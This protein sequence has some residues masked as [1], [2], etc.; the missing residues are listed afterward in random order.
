[1]M[2]PAIAIQGVGLVSSVGLSAP[3]SCAAIRAK[4]ANPSVTGF[5]GSSGERIIGHQVVLERPWRGVAK[6]ARMAAM[7]IAEG[8]SEVP[9]K[10]WTTIPLLLCVSERNRPGR[11]MNLEE[12]LPKSIGDLLGLPF[13]RQSAIIAHGRV[14]VVIALTQARKLFSQRGVNRVLI[15]AVDSLL[16][17]PTLRHLEGR[18]RLLGKRNSDGFLPGEGA[19]ALLLG[20]PRGSQ[21]L[22]CAGAGFGFEAATIASDMP[23][24][25]IGLTS[26][27]RGALGECGLAT[28][29]LDY[30]IADLSGEQY[31]FKEAALALLRSLR[32]RKPEFDL[33]HP[34]ECTGEAGAT[35]GAVPIAVGYMAGRVGYSPGDH[36]LAHMS[37]DNGERAAAVFRYVGA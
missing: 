24:R 8:L 4:V 6:L 23:L 3:T 18:G 17:W 33:W 30:R 28:H 26:A 12:S 19:C 15:V 7:S 29:D 25:A 1:M 10:E 31:Y 34:A 37:N 27:I 35:S 2:Q 11:L 22:L 16:N 21:E 36:V 13:A 20:N 32:E 9:R 14:G 5:V